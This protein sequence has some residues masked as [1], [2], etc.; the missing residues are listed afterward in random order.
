VKRAALVMALAT[1]LC[2][3]FG[4]LLVRLVVGV[5]GSLLCAGCVLVLLTSAGAHV[6]ARRRPAARPPL[7]RYRMTSAPRDI[8]PVHAESARPL[9]DCT[10]C[11]HP[12][13]G[14]LD[15]IDFCGTCADDY[16]AMRKTDVFEGEPAPSAG[17]SPDGDIR[18]TEA[19]AGSGTDTSPGSADMTEFEKRI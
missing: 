11:G 12:A 3:A 15:E 13:T 9:G 10:G 2:V 4:D 1:V 14:R 6:P 18:V 5:T 7:V 8:R 16:R 17:V 19:R